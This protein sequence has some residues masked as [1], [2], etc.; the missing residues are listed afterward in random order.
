MCFA[1]TDEHAAMQ[2]A[3]QRARHLGPVMFVYEVDLVDP[4]VDVNMHSDCCWLAADETVTSVMA[5][6]G[7]VTRIVRSTHEDHWPGPKLF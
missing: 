5:E 1:T 4:M 7:R 2:W 3:Y 6:S